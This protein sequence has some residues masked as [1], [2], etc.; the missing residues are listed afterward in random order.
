MKYGFVWFFKSNFYI[1]SLL[2]NLVAKIWKDC[3]SSRLQKM[4]TNVLCWMIFCIVCVCCTLVLCTTSVCLL[5]RKFL[6][7][8]SSPWNMEHTNVLECHSTEHLRIDI[9][10]THIG[11]T[12]WCNSA[13]CNIR[14]PYNDS[15]DGIE[16]PVHRVCAC[17]FRGD[18]QLAWDGKQLVLREYM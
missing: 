12:I 8:H 9:F 4:D 11:L 3:V 16:E 5:S 18:Q 10:F 15:G 7:N 2:N 13:G 6:W 1:G 17:W 14:S